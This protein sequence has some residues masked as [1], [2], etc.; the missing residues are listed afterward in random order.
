MAGSLEASFTLFEK[1]TAPDE[2]AVQIFG[3]VQLT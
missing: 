3:T 1:L 2:K